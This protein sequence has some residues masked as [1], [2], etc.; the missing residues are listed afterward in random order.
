MK[1]VTT[2]RIFTLAVCVLLT[3]SVTVGGFSYASAASADDIDAQIGSILD[4][5]I[6]KAGVSSVQQL[7]DGELASKAGISSEW[8]VFAL[9]QYEKGYDFNA[10]ASALKKHIT[11]NPK[12]EMVYAISFACLGINYEYISQTLADSIGKFGIISWIFG[13]QLMNNGYSCKGYSQT[14]A[15]NK[16]LSLQLADG[17]FALSGTTADVDVTAMTVQA[18]SKHYNLNELVKKAVNKAVELLSERQRADGGFTSYGVPNPESTAQVITALTALDIDCLNDS[19]FIKN[20]NNLLDA[21]NKFKLRDGSFCHEEGKE[22]ND[23]ATVQALYSLVALWRQIK[24]LSPLYTFAKKA[25]PAQ[26]TAAPVIVY[27][28]SGTTKKSGTTATSAV[29]TTRRSNRR[30]PTERAQST[31]APPKKAATTSIAQTAAKPVIQAATFAASVVTSADETTLKAEPFATA[32][33]QYTTAERAADNQLQTVTD[34]TKEIDKPDY[35]KIV[36]AVFAI[37][38]LAACALLLITGK[39]NPKNFIAVILIAGAAFAVNAFVD[40]QSKD[41]FYID[42]SE[43]QEAQGDVTVTLSIRC[44]NIVGLSQDDYIPRDGT[45][46]AESEFTVNDGATVYDVL[47]LA[48]RQNNIQIENSSAAS[49]SSAYI[50]GINYIYEF[51]F[52]DL[53]GWRYKVNGEFPSVGCGGYTVKS[54]DKIEWQYSLNLGEDLQ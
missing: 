28:Q 29:T 41:D 49:D 45:I 13:L 16:L 42:K 36:Y 17:G 5:M 43:T 34:T 2:K 20:G 26:T 8:Y 53:S 27:Y 15:V 31:T 40:I 10:Y 3:V 1:K 22:S 9:R 11:T 51:D 54:G 21:L 46:L 39:R 44:D 37:A 33:A 19:R 4:Y 6:N 30:Q 14:E 52:G 35:K 50:S 18:L 24:E 38:A 12:Y 32:A 47:V 25:V 7:I 23:N 48:A